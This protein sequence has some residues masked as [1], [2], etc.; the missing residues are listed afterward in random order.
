[1]ALHAATSSQILICLITIYLLPCLVFAESICNG[2]QYGNPNYEAC[3][4][5]LFDNREEHL[6]GIE[7]QDRKDHVFVPAGI[8][9]RPAD[10][11]KNQWANRVL[12]PEIWSKCVFMPYP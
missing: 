11:T 10:V 9:E 5:L 2:Y 7:S 1:M 3:K 12:L 4:E 6:K 8:T